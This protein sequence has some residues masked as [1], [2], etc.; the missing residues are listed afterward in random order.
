MKCYV[1]KNKLHIHNSEQ[2]CNP[3]EKSQNAFLYLDYLHCIWQDVCVSKSK[4][5]Q[6][7]AKIH[8]KKC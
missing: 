7:F 8:F 5:T 1:L 3:K 4:G 6:L 2:R